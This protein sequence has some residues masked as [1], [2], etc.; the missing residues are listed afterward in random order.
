MGQLPN[1]SLN[2]PVRPVHNGHG[3]FPR[4]PAPKLQSK[5]N[6]S[7]TLTI[8]L[9]IPPP[10]KL[11]LVSL[12]SNSNAYMVCPIFP[13]PR[14]FSKLTW[15]WRALKVILGFKLHGLVQRSLTK[16]NSG[17]WELRSNLHI[18]QSNKLH[19]GLTVLRMLLPTEI[20]FLL[21][22]DS[23]RYL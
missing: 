1:L 18:F 12:G 19:Y 4:F 2:S 17:G 10:K 13:L 22:Y 9:M 7:P 3:S 11:T 21:L 20:T 6:K 8:I 16:W 5:E 15:V 23:C 14:I